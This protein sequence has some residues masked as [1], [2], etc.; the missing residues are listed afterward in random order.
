MSIGWNITESLPSF[1]FADND[2][3]ASDAVGD[4]AIAAAY[5]GGDSLSKAIFTS[6]GIATLDTSSYDGGGEAWRWYGWGMA[7]EI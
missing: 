4:M 7:S 1:D 3:D 5:S 2:D 6:S